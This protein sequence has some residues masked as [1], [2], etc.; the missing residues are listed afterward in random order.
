MVCDRL[1]MIAVIYGAGAVVRNSHGRIEP[2][3]VWV[4]RHT[5]HVD[6]DIRP[7]GI[8]DIDR[9]ARTRVED[10]RIARLIYDPEDV[11]KLSSYSIY[12]SDIGSSVGYR[13]AVKH[14]DR[15]TA[16]VIQNGEAYLEGINQAFLKPLFAYWQDRSVANDKALRNWLLTI[17][18]TKWHYLHGARDPESISPDN[19]VLDQAYQDRPGNKEIQLS[20]LY[21]EKTNLES[22]AALAELF[23]SASTSRAHCLGPKRWDFHGRGRTSLSA[24]P[25]RRRVSLVRHGPFRAGEDLDRIGPLIHE[26]LDRKVAG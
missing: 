9:D 5:A 25:E 14:P 6:T 3:A 1:G 12:L 19:W 16:L 11:S 4:S 15:V 23:S 24:G 17:E 2:E 22:Y 20:I 13:L 26:F 8:W 7:V 10:P 18:G 21:D